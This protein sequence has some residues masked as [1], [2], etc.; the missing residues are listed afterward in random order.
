MEEKVQAV[1]KLLQEEGDSFGKRAEM[2]YKRRPELI[3]FVEECFRAYRSLA[4]RYDH[5]SRDL[6]N[7]NNTIAAN[8]PDKVPYIDED[9][10]DAGSP[11]R[12][13]KKMPEGF[14]QGNIPSP[15][16]K[17][18]KNLLKTATKKL[19]PNK[20]PATKV[21]FTLP[22]KKSGLSKEE[23]IEQVDKHQKEILELQTVKEYLKSSYDNSIAKYKETDEQIKK[24][25]E[26][27]SQFQDELGGEGVAIED[28]VARHLMAEVAL[29]SCQATLAQ[30]QEKQ[31]ASQD[32]TRIES[33]RVQETRGKLV[34]LVNELHNNPNE[35]EDPE[36]KSDEKEAAET[37]ELQ[38]DA[39]KI[40]Q[41][42]QEVQLLQEKIREHFEAGSH[43]PLTVTEMA[44]KIDELVNKVVSLESA[45]SSQSA[46]VATWKAQ[47]DELNALIKVL[48]SD[49]ESMMNDKIRLNEQLREMEEKLHGVQNLNRV[50]E[51]QNSNLETHFTEAQCN[52][53]TLTEKV[54]N[55]KSDED[56]EGKNVPSSDQ[57]N[58][59]L[60]AAISRKKSLMESKSPSKSQTESLS[61]S[62]P[63]LGDNPDW[64]QLFT[65]GL[66]GREKALLTEY[67]NALRNYKEAKNQLAELEKK[68]QDA[69]FDSSLQ[70]KELKSANA[71]KD[72]EI[73]LLRQKLSLLQKSIKGS[74]VFR[75][76][77]PEQTAEIE[78]IE[79]ILQR[80]ESKSATIANSLVIEEMLDMEEPEPI[81]LIEEKFRMN[82]D[83]LLEENLDFWMRFTATITEIQRYQTQVKDLLIEERRLE[84]KWKASEGSSSARYSLRSDVRPLYKHLA[85]IRMEMQSWMESI[86]GL[87][88]ELEQR[89]KSLCEMQEEILTALKA[90]AEDDEITFT[91]YQAAK[92][93]GELLNMK[94]GNNKISD[95][96]Q[97]GLDII[98]TLQIEVEKVLLKMVEKFGLSTHN[99]TQPTR[100]SESQNR[101]P[102][103]SFIF[104]VKPIKKQNKNIFSKMTPGMHKK[105]RGTKDK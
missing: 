23:L 60:N 75:D 95:G 14:F 103:K 21:K 36:A 84:E 100:S 74:Q 18:L 10:D 82:I 1:L 11:T 31:A 4:D 34:S 80:E 50:V 92:F 104:G 5:L 67:T 12:P 27:V 6:Q 89:F 43:S 25:Q 28:E 9:D 55:V 16:T 54:Q 35:A 99:K 64:Q 8:C 76:L 62:M 3:S 30:L 86:V 39:D 98:T 7:A 102:L 38:D 94:Q 51:D 24:L 71:V 81:S 61:A 79:E 45:V 97:T 85:E 73:R 91:S 90:S 13:P 72:E 58:V 48:E 2:Y 56:A 47:T 57:E 83:E 52:L 78:A 105:H 69:L 32:L 41:H 19:N 29:K 68:S 46:L 88:E 66:E 44:E 59:L 101:V 93:Q 37:K 20:K 77:P 22:P 65:M 63:E 49:K 17:E 26:K 15:P 96:L 42:Q 33:K 53:E 87:K 70:L 40:A